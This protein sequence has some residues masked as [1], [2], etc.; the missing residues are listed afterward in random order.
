MANPL[1]TGVSGLSVHQKMIEVIGNNIANINSTA[2][3]ARR[4]YFS[5]VF[6]ETIRSAT[7]GEVGQIGG[8][9]A[10]Q[11]GTGAKVA[12]ISLD[13]RQGNMETTGGQLDFALEG[14]GFFTMD[15]GRGPLYT[16]A[17]VFSI[18]KNGILV[19]A[20][21]GYRIQRFGTVGEPDGIN[22]AFQIPGATEIRIPIGES[23]PGNK[24]T[25][26]V[27]RGNLS[28]STKTAEYHE[29]A[30]SHPL[31]DGAIP[32]TGASL[33]N[34]LDWVTTPFQA[35]DSIEMSG[36]DVDGNAISTSLSVD[37]TTTVD[38]LLSSLSSSFPGTTASIDTDGFLRLVADESGAVP[39]IVN[40]ANGSTNVG[41]LDVV[42]NPLFIENAGEDGNI[43][44]GGIEVFDNRGE[45]HVVGLAF[46]PQADGTWNMLATMDSAEG[47][48]L[49]SEINGISFNSDGSFAGIQGSAT[50]ELEFQ[51]VGQVDPQVVT[52]S[53]GT[54]GS[55]N[56]L[57]SISGESSIATEQDG[58][59]PGTLNSVSVDGNGI[60]D[61]LATNGRRIPLAQLAI[62]SFRN[63]A[64]LENRGDGTLQVTRSSGD[65]Q[66][67]SAQSGGRGTI[68]SGQLEQSNVDIAAEFTRL[69]IAQRGFSANARTI[70][71]ANEMLQELTQILR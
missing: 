9:N 19:D 17:G 41:Q 63:P 34:S 43:I 38:D 67:G 71:V 6:Y 37:G 52:I 14:E 66:L 12:T 27:L 28:S 45:G 31:L 26:T 59:P 48:I 58:F 35:G 21:T 57:K 16:R 60:I 33:L 61:G 36:T 20:S 55:L 5:D 49:T 11:I 3:K 50:G 62:A 65:V 29:I 4:A 8:T 30:T 70:T 42:S 46:E 69:I 1:I 23:I 39:M 7:S 10:S 22:P 15:T 53:F 24:T 64:G 44:R 47:D 68:R 32:A 25:E 54:P 18:D 56:G 51:F 40:L 13:G 2:F